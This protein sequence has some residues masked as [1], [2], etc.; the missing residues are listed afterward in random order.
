MPQELDQRQTHLCV[1]QVT[2]DAVPDADR[3]RLICAIVIV[4]KGLLCLLEVSLGDELIG[5]SEVV[6]GKVGSEMADAYTGLSVHSFV[7]H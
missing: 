6:I 7:S 2:P 3:P 4:L 1:G 5:V